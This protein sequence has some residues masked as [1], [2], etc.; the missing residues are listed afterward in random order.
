MRTTSVELVGSVTA[1]LDSEALTGAWNGAAKVPRLTCPSDPPC[2]RIPEPVT[3]PIWS[4]ALTFAV[5]SVALLP[6]SVMNPSS[7]AET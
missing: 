1:L 4:V 6:A 3:S 7:S 5:A 2:S